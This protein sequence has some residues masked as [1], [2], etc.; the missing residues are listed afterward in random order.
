VKVSHLTP[1][2]VLQKTVGEDQA[3]GTFDGKKN[4]EPAKDP[5]NEGDEADAEDADEGEINDEEEEKAEDPDS[6]KD[7]A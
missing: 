1:G 4:H 7:K 3:D 6:E 5:K 2:E